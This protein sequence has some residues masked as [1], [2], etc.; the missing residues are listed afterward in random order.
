MVA[1]WLSETWGLLG[2]INCSTTLANNLKSGIT[3]MISGICIIGSLRKQNSNQME[4]LR[5]K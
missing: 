5:M 3:G 2:Y 4:R 1:V